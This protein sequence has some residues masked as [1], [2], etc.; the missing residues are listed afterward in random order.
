MGE[1]YTG[2]DYEVYAVD[3]NS[4]CNGCGH[5]GYWRVFGFGGNND[6]ARIQSRVYN[7]YGR[8]TDLEFMIN[9]RSV[10]KLFYNKA[11]F[12]VPAN[13]KKGI[14]TLDLEVTKSNWADHVFDGN[15]DLMPLE[16]VDAFVKKNKHL[17]NIPSEK[18]IR[19]NGYSMKEMNIRFI[20]K[21]EELYLHVI[22]LEQK[23]K[24]L[25]TKIK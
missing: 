20:E 21:I 19:E 23:I 5:N 12:N 10:F 11:D 15:Y 1:S 4:K 18:E 16:K 14:K 17:P 24:D 9:Q 13:F 7:W 8:I 6:D 2:T 22:K 3:Y 25:K